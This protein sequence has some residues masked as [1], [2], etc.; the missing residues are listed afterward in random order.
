MISGLSLNIKCVLILCKLSWNI[1][2]SKN[3]ATFCHTRMSRD[4][5]VKFLLFL[6]DFNES[7]FSW[8]IFEKYSVSNDMKICAVGAK[9]FIAERDGWANMIKLTV[10]LHD[11]VNTPNSCFSGSLIVIFK[12]KNSAFLA[13]G[14]GRILGLQFQPNSRPALQLILMLH[15]AVIE[16]L[17][18]LACW[19]CWLVNS[20]QSTQWPLQITWFFKASN[21]TVPS[22]NLT[23]KISGNYRFSHLSMVQNM[24][25]TAVVACK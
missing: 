22:H 10:A 8:Q 16:N 15:I 24:S 18:L 21:I 3:S 4:I 23:S 5:Y 20:Y 13:V 1:S 17:S 14:K 12:S 11:F 25:N 9:F 2:Y 6:T 19:P 7:Y